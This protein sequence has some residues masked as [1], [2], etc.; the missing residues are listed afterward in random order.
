[1][2]DITMCDNF[3]CNLRDKCYRY[4]AEPDEYNQSYSL[5]SPT[6]NIKTKEMECDYFLTIKED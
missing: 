4:M 1:M 5:F 2:A 6:I 3:T